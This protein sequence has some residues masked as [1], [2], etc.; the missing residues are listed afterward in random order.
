M[1]QE[2]S[3]KVANCTMYI[4]IYIQ[5]YVKLFQI[6]QLQVNHLNTFQI[7]F[8]LFQLTFST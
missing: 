7:D 1:N 6:W 4:Y 5:I 2:L 8:Q 3:N